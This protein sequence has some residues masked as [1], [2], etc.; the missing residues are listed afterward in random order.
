[1]SFNMRKKDEVVINFVNL[2]DK[3]HRH[4]GETFLVSVL[5]V[6]RS[7]TLSW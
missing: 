3:V 7:C 6:V 4:L 1:M 2:N 5:V